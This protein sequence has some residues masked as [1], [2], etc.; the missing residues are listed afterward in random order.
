MCSTHVVCRTPGVEVGANLHH[1]VRR[2]PY[3][4]DH[5]ST[6]SS[7]CRA[8]LAYLVTAGEKALAPY[9]WLCTWL[10]TMENKVGCS[11]ARSCSPAHPSQ[12]VT[13]KTD[14]STTTTWLKVPAVAERRTPSAAFARFHTP[15]SRKRWTSRRVASHTRQGFYPVPSP[16]NLVTSY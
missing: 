14:K 4:S 5:V 10:R 9:L 6:T 7:L 12:S 11:V 2:R 16:F 13:S 8:P 1:R 3:K 15:L